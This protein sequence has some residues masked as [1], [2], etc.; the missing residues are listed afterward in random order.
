[1]RRIPGR[2]EY[3]DSVGSYQVDT[4]ATCLGGNKE[5]P[6]I[7]IFLAVKV[8]TPFFADI[9]RRGPIHPV[10]IFAMQPRPKSQVR[11]GML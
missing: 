5:E 9:S 1:M 11:I 6:H 10:V 8:G 3:Y 4:K 7:A 2:I